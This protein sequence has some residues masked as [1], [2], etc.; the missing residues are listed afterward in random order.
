MEQQTIMVVDDAE[1]NREMLK[2]ILGDQYH[3]IEA[4]DGRLFGC[5]RNSRMW[6]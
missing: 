6:T 3:Y 5:L 4:A 2:D 1:I